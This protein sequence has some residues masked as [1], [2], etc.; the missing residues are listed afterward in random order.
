MAAK[1]SE[2][3]RL[4]HKGLSRRNIALSLPC[5]RNTVA[6]V[7]DRAKELKIEWPLPDGMTEK[8]LEEFLLGKPDG[9]SQTKRRMPDYE[10]IR[11]ELLKNGVNK[12][13]LW[14]EYLEECKQTGEQPLMYSHFCYHI[15]QEEQKRRATAH[16]PRKPGE[17]IEVDW[18][19]DPAYIINPDTGKR[20]EAK[21]FVGVLSYSQYAYVEAFPN[22][23][24]KS[25]IKAHVHM[26]SY[27]NGVSK[28]LVPD[29]TGTAV[30]NKGDWYTQELNETYREMAEHYGTA[31]IPARVKKP[32]DKPNAEGNVGHVS[33][34]IVAALRNEQFFSL[35]ELN[36]AI[37]LKLYTYNTESFQKKEGSRKKLFEEEEKPCLMPLPK[38]DFEISEWKRATVQY[39]YHVAFDKMYYSVPSEEIGKEVH[40]RATEST[41]EVYQGNERIA[42]HARLYGKEGQY[43][44]IAE[45]MPKDHQKY[46]EWNGDRF[47]KWAK[48]IGDD[49]FKVIDAM[50]KIAAIE[51]QAYRGCMGL[52]KLA[53]K[54]SKSKLDRACGKAL[55]Y[56][57]APS[58]KMV[59][60]ILVSSN[61][62]N[63]TVEENVNKYGITRGADYYRR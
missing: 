7:L 37:L 16:I 60:N 6:K 45:H 31:V 43:S 13:L 41:I 40:I 20:E 39:N 24:T 4:N 59:K 44:T 56:T 23:K 21:I 51:Q 3:L 8:K 34:W 11:K 46:F 27:F 19:G 47:R 2:I 14:T 25:W 48:G 57:S 35:E 42:S 54:Y 22:E 28:I 18:A 50:L 15:Q 55:E 17:Q 62:P 52:L 10:Y 29:N 53:D 33:T 38:K 32:K 1:Y 49:T 26:F 61:T 36:E 5:S 9:K 12:K 63:E 30:N 58:Y